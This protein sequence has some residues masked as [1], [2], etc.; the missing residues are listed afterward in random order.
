MKIGRVKGDRIGKT[1]VFKLFFS[2]NYMNSQLEDLSCC[3]LP[4]FFFLSQMVI[5]LSLLVIFPPLCYLYEKLIFKISL[6]PHERIFYSVSCNSSGFRT[7]DLQGFCILFHPDTCFIAV[8]AKTLSCF[9]LTSVEKALKMVCRS[10]WH[11]LIF[12]LPVEAIPNQF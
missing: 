10:L 8:I 12:R 1:I 2:C 11:L 4:F 7:P 9:S 5:K 6:C 3:S